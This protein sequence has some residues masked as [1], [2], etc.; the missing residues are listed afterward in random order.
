[1]DK[2]RY[3]VRDRKL[4]IGRE[5]G[6]IIVPQMQGEFL[7]EDNELYIKNDNVKNGKE[8]TEHRSIDRGDSI[9]AGNLIVTFFEH[10][11]EI[12]GDMEGC[13]CDLAPYT[14]KEIPFEGFPYYKKSPR[15][16]HRV[17]PETI[18][19][20]V[21]P[22]KETMSKSSLVQIIIPPLM[23]MAVT[24][25]MSIFMK[26]GLYV[27]ASVC[28][29]GVTTIFSIQRFFNERKELKKK[30]TARE[31]VY[32][33]YLVR[34]RGHIR[35]QRARERETLDYQTPDV[36]VLESMAL[37]YDSRM[38]ERGPEDEDFLQVNLGYCSGE[39]Q[40]R[41][42]GEEDELD[43][44]ED[45]L[46]DEAKEL[47]KDFEIL[48][49][50]PVTVNLRSAH[51]GIVGESDNIHNQLKYLLMQLCF[52]H[53]Y[54]DLQIIFIGNEAYEKEFSYL[55]WYPHLRI[56]AINAVAGIFKS[57]TRDQILG[58]I[59]QMVKDRKQKTDESNKQMAFLPHLLF[60]IDEPGLIRDHAIMEY[61]GRGSRELGIS[62]IYTTDQVPKLPEN[63]GTVCVLDNSESGHLLLDEG[64]RCERSFE[65][66]SMKERNVSQV[67]RKS[68][69]LIHEKG[70]VSR[71]PDSITFFEM[72]HVNKPEELLAPARWNNH[73]A[74]KS[75]AVPLGVREQDNYVELNLHEK[76][77]GPHGL[78]AGT[79]GSG[80]S[81][82]IQS[83][84][85][86]LAV[87]FHPYEVGFLLID[88]KG[89]GMANLFQKLPHL[90]GTIT[91]LDGAE[92]YRAMVSIKS[93]LARRQRIF[94]EY[95][96]NHING[97]HKLYKL[98]KA[99]EPIPHLFLISDEFAELKK[100]QPEFMKELVSTARIGR[101]LGIHLILATQKPSGVV[102]EQIWTNS[103]FKLCLKVQ[104]EAD[105]REMLKT[106]DAATITQA[107]RA[108]L[109]VGNNEIYELFQSAFSGASYSE[110]DEA[111][112][113]GDKRVYLVNH[114]G[115]GQ[116]INQDLGGSLESNQIKKTQLDVVV[117][118]LERSFE[119]LEL[120]KVKSPWLP[121][122]T[123]I[124]VSP[125]FDNI[126]DS[127]AYSELCLAV[128]VGVED[129]P[130]EQRQ[131]EYMID[132]LHDG[133][134][135]FFASTGY[136]KTVFLE[137]ILLSLCA[138][139]SVKNL[140]V[141][142][143]DFGN[144]ALLPLKSLPHV[145]DYITY[146]DV[147]KQQKLISL[148]LKEIKFRKQLMA[149]AMAQNLDIYNQSA[150]RKL[151]AIVV[152]LDNY[153][154][155]K[156]LGID[157]NFFVQLARD[158]ANLG[159][160]LAVT[161][162]RSSVVKYALMNQIKTKIA[163]YN[164]E[165][166]EA[167]NIVGRSEY[168]IPDIKGRTLVKSETINLMQVYSPV[169]YETGLQ[170]NRNLL[171]LIKQIVN[172]STEEKAKGIAVLPEQFRLSM[173][174]D[175][176]PG[177]KA[178]IYL[179]LEKQNV[180]RFGILTSDTPFL[181]VGPV[182]SGKSNACRI[183]LNQMQEFEKVFLFDSKN[184]ELQDIGERENVEYADSEQ[185][186]KECIEELA[187]LIEER[188]EDYMTGRG[189]L[190]AIQ[191]YQSLPKYCVF[192]NELMDFSE[193]IKDDAKVVST[194]S[195]AAGTGILVAMSGHSAHMPARNETAKL[196][197]SA[198]NGL[199]L[200][201]PGMNTAFPTFRGKELPERIEDG[202]LYRKG[203]SMMIRLPK[204]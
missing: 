114:L 16:I 37:T 107:G 150:S 141:Y 132:F 124:M 84:I 168:E 35:K 25:F 101:S 99:T 153:D 131:A 161:A 76:D 145:A 155:V 33:D 148:L 50:I 178:D 62:I 88:Y 183:M 175:Y 119:E 176:E 171:A 139:N 21:P 111:S 100:E 165:P 102:D 138:R 181:I 105:S 44:T 67:S 118:Y 81:E 75:L 96:V 197:K 89:G 174:T 83:Y 185:A 156:E 52:F 61:L 198:E 95:G 68:A 104:N 56:Q 74:H 92:S 17:H 79:T 87:N 57:S 7:I 142:I 12:T 202:V 73:E 179:G 45:E 42:L 60:I 136:G 40:I 90:L 117:E 134:V 30:N 8:E 169:T 160:Y 77:H 2:A 59:L 32:T 121:P 112:E 34:L 167:R 126:S 162:S 41:V 130:G 194:I 204:A 51:L 70:M 186:L 29:T 151:E 26:R 39:S 154:V 31:Q 191:F 170:Y 93:E 36:Q 108:Y 190:S 23:M 199:I 1:M 189:K 195:E 66:V 11:L 78:V 116:L 27:I 4:V 18:N 5:R 144:N 22:R 69:A 115:Q 203:V 54:H 164:Y 86:S 128:P 46:L 173:L 158:G 143:M 133:H 82:I 129:I 163:G 14:F 120:P 24:V 3:F 196:V 110:E 65:T 193:L 72:Y 98:G 19:V 201:D 177:D 172:A 123:E 47:V 109:Q 192:I 9:Q 140:H 38:Y 125:V 146:D 187:D 188:K 58:S 103:R 20:K 97:Y 55:R 137:T 159:I 122:L 184:Y 91:N 71:I 113:E 13:Q 135:I 147:E 63:I 85:L 152:F 64:I 157:E 49:H 106:P 200:G 15:V 94:N 6:N 166:M 80:K 53:S 127:A 43:M 149:D 48:P 180:K 182:R 10:Y 28:M